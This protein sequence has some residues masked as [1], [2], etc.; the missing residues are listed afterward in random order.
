MCMLKQKLDNQL[1][2][3]SKEFFKENSDLSCPVCG[4][5]QD[6][7]ISLQKKNSVVPLSAK[8]PGLKIQESQLLKDW[9]Q[10]NIVIGQPSFGVYLDE[11]Y[12]KYEEFC[13]KE[14][15]VD[16]ISKKKFLKAILYWASWSVPGNQVIYRQSRYCYF[17]GLSYEPEILVT[18]TQ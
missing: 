11:L 1:P 12:T 9:I 10:K 18:K 6:H 17:E 8:W 5:L 2:I 4:H 15:E 3:F 14:K 16:A 7:K 13:S